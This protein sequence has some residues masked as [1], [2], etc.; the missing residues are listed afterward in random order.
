MSND[1]FTIHQAGR[2]NNESD[3]RQAMDREERRPRRETRDDARDFREERQVRDARTATFADNGAGAGVETFMKT[4]EDIYKV[5]PAPADMHILPLTGEVRRMLNSNGYLVMLRQINKDYYWHLLVI[6][7]S[8]KPVI[9]TSLKDRRRDPV[10]VYQATIDGM[11]KEVLEPIGKWVY[12]QISN[13]VAGAMVI[14]TSCTIIP[15]D[16]D[17]KDVVTVRN[18]LNAADDANFIVAG[19]DEP[20][21]ADIL[22]DDAHIKGQLGFTGALEFDLDG[23]PLRAEYTGSITQTS[24]RSVNNP[25][26]ATSSS[27]TFLTS[28]GYVDLFYIGTD[29]DNRSRDAEETATL[30]P[31]IYTS[32]NLYKDKSYGALERLG[33]GLS[34]IPFLNTNDR[35]MEQFLANLDR[36]NCDIRALGYALDLPDAAPAPLDCE[37]DELRPVRQFPK[38]MNKFVDSEE[39]ARVA[40]QVREGA[41]G[42]AVTKILL[43]I[44]NGSADAADVL[45]AAWDDLTDNRFSDNMKA[46]GCRRIVEEAIRI[47]DGTYTSRNG[48]RPATDIDTVMVLNR[49]GADDVDMIDDWFSCAYPGRCAYDETERLAKLVDIFNAVTGKSFVMT[50]YRTDVYLDPTALECLFEA[51]QKSDLALDVEFNGELEF[52][53]GKRYNNRNYSGLRKDLGRSGPRHTNGFRRSSYSETSYRRNR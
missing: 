43:D 50:G 40:L 42:F 22:P 9:V 32:L 23:A 11:T 20:F 18:I 24:E 6:E 16:A 10:N 29:P 49:F 45:T 5:N 13:P 41:P 7:A 37:I 31:V 26:M 46:A 8:N 38:V 4:L 44:A 35:W 14:H 3:E 15:A 28:T 33:M 34:M 39:G 12:D 21:N 36:T 2:S 48:T 51:L 19:V 27:D 25:L 30:A 52:G 1:T 53:R 47:P 17:L